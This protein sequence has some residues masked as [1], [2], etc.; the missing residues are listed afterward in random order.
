MFHENS[1]VPAYTLNLRGIHHSYLKYPTHVKKVGYTSEFLFSIYWWTW[2]TNNY[3]KNCWSGPI[4]NKMIF[5]IHNAAFKKKKER[6]TPVHNHYRNLDDMIHSSWNIEQNILKLVILGQFL[7]FYPPKKTQN[8]NFEKWKNLLRYH[9]LTNVYQKLQSYD[10]WFRK[11]KVR[12]AECF[13]ILG[14]F[15]SF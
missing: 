7:P 1:F 10:V 12:Q 5:N 11:Y 13:A 8:L 4:K 3:L 6:K 14:H 2:N 9:H 15:F